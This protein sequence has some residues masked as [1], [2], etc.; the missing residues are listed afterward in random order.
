MADGREVH[1]R[2]RNVASRFEVTAR[3][4]IAGVILSGGASRRMGTPK[5]LLKFRD[6]TFLDRLF[7][8]L[9]RVCSPVI[10]VVGTHSE[11]IRK[12][13]ASASEVL[14]AENPDPERGMLSSLQ[15]GLA[16]VP[17]D[18]DAAMFLPVD[19]PHIALDTVELLA[20][21]FRRD[22]ALVTV[23]VYAGEHGHPV[24]IA[25]PLIDELLALPPGAKA[26]D[27]IHRHIARTVYIEVSDPAVVTDVDDPAAYAQLLARQV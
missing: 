9:A 18:A 22:R 25:R 20:E 23:P 19:H 7:D 11:Q 26:S 3:A 13:I 5:A 24:C 6:E 21:R 12:G 14:F 1:L 10:V 15:C 17:K 16:L 27:V 8:V 2:E 4:K